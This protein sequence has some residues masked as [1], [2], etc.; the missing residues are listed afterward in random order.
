MKDQAQWNA[1]LHE[2]LQAHERDRVFSF[3]YNNDIYFVKKHEKNHRR[4]IRWGGSHG[5]EH[6]AGHMKQVNEATGLAPK[7]VLDT[8]DFFVTLGGGFSLNELVSAEKKQHLEA[9]V[10]VDLEHIFNRVGEALGRLHEAG[11]TH[12]RPV[13]RDIVYNPQSDSVQFLDWENEYS[14]NWLDQ[15]RLDVLLFV[16]GYFRERNVEIS[17]INAAMQGYTRVSGGMKRLKGLQAMLRK[18]RFLIEFLKIFKPIGGID[19]LALLWA[20]DYLLGV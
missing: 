3:T 20:Y 5:Y 14:I 11:F 12:G 13:L 9:L 16:H 6:E 2:A 19:L 4:R 1:C 15:K 8:E 18:Q 17:Y 10:E 7:V